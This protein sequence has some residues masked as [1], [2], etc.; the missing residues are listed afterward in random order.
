M[1]K[2]T[3][4]KIDLRSSVEAKGSIVTQII[5]FIGGAKKTIPGIKTETIRQGQF[6]K[7]ETTDGR[8]VMINDAN[9]LCI[10]VFTE[11]NGN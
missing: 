3:F 5:T 1:A 6:T 11:K 2:Q 8:L 9:V 7:F 10:E 4:E